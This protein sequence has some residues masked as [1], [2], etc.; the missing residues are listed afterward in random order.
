VSTQLEIKIEKKPEGTVVHFSGAIDEDSNFSSLDAL[1]EEQV[2][3]NLEKI[4]FINSC[5]IREWIKY[6]DQMRSEIKVTYKKCPQVIIE[7]MNIVKGFI[8][9]GGSIESFYAPYYNEKTD[10]EI[11]IL[12]T[13][14]QVINH[15]APSVKSEDGEQLDFDDIEAQYFNFLKHL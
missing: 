15:K 7:Q 14:S 3:F 13:P 6:Q 5:G 8:K 11:K 9:A 10:E 1:K 4:T 2:I 12:I